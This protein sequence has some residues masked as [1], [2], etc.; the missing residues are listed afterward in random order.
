M[1]EPLKPMAGS[2]MEFGEEVRLSTGTIL[3][4]ASGVVAVFSQP[5]VVFLT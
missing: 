2:Q 5:V 1:A 4:E 3:L